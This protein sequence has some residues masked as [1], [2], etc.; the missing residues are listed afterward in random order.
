M[1]NVGIMNQANG[2][3]VDTI[4]ENSS[5]FILCMSYEITLTH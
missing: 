5:K 3:W 1:A 2:I 4:K